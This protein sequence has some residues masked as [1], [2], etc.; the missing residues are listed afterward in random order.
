LVKIENLSGDKE[1]KEVQEEIVDKQVI[2]AS[3]TI[4]DGKGDLAP[5][6]PEFAVIG[7]G[8]TDMKE[9]ATSYGGNNRQDYS[10]VDRFSGSY[11]NIDYDTKTE[12]DN[13]YPFVTKICWKMR[14][15][16]DNN[17]AIESISLRTMLNFNRIYE[18]EMLV[19]IG[20]PLK[21]DG[22]E[23]EKIKRLQDSVESFITTINPKSLGDKMRQIPD[24]MTTVQ[25]G[26]T[27]LRAF[28]RHFWLKHASQNP[29]TGEK[30]QDIETYIGQNL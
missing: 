17:N 13:I 10:L 29:H 30:T 15:F 23:D 8:N 18:A 9:V 4:K 16:L 28:T 22:I 7:T 2:F 1:Y 14:E 26:D 6:H 27:D 25:M 20:S 5:K 24:L 11:Y 12:S 19:N 21:I 3:P